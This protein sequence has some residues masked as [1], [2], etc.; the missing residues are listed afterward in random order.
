[1]RTCNGCG[2]EK[3]NLEDKTSDFGWKR[4]YRNDGTYLV[5]YD[6]KCKM[7]RRELD[8]ARRISKT[9]QKKIN[10]TGPEGIEKQWFCYI[11]PTETDKV[12]R[13]DIG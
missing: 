9:M 2:L 13:Y 7:C 12:K 6:G 3:H 5:Q 4:R 1:M 11:M 8:R 10:H